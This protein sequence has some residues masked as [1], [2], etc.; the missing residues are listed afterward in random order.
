M[1]GCLIR[2][3]LRTGSRQLTRVTTDSNPLQEV[4]I[5]LQGARHPTT[6]R[7]RSNKGVI[8]LLSS[9]HLNSMGLQP[10]RSL[11]VRLL[12]RVLMVNL[13]RNRM[14]SSLL[15]RELMANLRRS[16]MVSSP[17]IQLHRPTVHHQRHM[18]NPLHHNLTASHRRRR[19]TDSSH[20]ALRLPS[21]LARRQH[22][23]R[24]TVPHKS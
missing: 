8:I 19:H 4:N 13:R 3:I 18:A 10:R 2:T 15:L 14:V 11:M 24:A 5:H 16:H 1:T 23:H 22:H 21:I 9:L 20:M 6:H 12:L 17:L 7:R